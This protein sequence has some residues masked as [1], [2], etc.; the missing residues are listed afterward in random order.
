MPDTLVKYVDPDNLARFYD[1]VSDRPVYA[2]D[3]V[4]DMQ[5]ATYLEAGMTCHTNGYTTATDGM[6]AFYTIAASGDIACANSLYA[7]RVDSDGRGILVLG[8]SYGQ[9][10]TPDGTVS[11]WI[12]FFTTR[13]GSYGYTVYSNA[14]GGTGFWR[15]DSNKRFSTLASNLIATLSDTEKASIGTVIIGGGYNDCS[16][17]QANIQTGMTELKG[18][19][20]TSLP[21]VCKVL[22][23]PFG[24]AVQ[25]LTTGDHSGFQYSGIVSMVKNYVGANANS[26]LGTIV[27]EANMLLRRNAY[28]SSDYVHPNQNGQFIIGCFV[29]DVFFG[30]CN[31]ML[32]QKFNDIY[33]PNIATVSAMGVINNT[34]NPLVKTSGTKLKLHWDQTQEMTVNPNPAINFTCDNGH[35]LTLGTFNDAAI[36]QY[37]DILIPVSML[38]RSTTST[39]L[40]YQ[41]V[42]GELR[43]TN[44]VMKLN[45]TAANATGNNFLTIES[46]DRIVVKPLS[47]PF[48][49]GL[50]LV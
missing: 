21:N 7:T 28:F 41:Q 48:V 3:T 14:L 31:S 19:I 13:V 5:S 46:I 30:N 33:V 24:M 20:T 17:T 27:G 18:V 39:P 47:L 37:G 26:E 2:F 1:N 43:I 29:A 49:D 15:D 16:N 9:G 38:I 36:Q 10:Y 50:T 42:V 12:E 4:A 8:D 32:A 35:P 34:N 11:S 25:G 44:G 22:V 23:F 6:G 45:A 40:R